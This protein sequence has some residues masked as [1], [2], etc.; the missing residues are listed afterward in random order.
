MATPKQLSLRIKYAKTSLTTLTKKLNTGKAKVKV[1]EADL[2]KAK[3]ATAKK[4]CRKKSLSGPRL[5]RRY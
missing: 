5:P 2:K 1:L 3:C 4:K